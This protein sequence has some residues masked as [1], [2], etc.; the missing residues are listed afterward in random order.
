MNKT[1]NHTRTFRDTGISIP[2]KSHETSSEKS[3][4]VFGNVTESDI[5]KKICLRNYGI[6]EGPQLI[7]N[8]PF[9]LLKLFRL[10]V[11]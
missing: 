6:V 11:K 10:C 5:T 1:K 7:R 9:G 8:V 4:V 2:L 3:K